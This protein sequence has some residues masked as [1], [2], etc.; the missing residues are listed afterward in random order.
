MI[1]KTI[2]ERLY[3]DALKKQQ[4]IK[5]GFQGGIISLVIV[6]AINYLNQEPQLQALIYTSIGGAVVSLVSFYWHVS[7]ACQVNRLQLLRNLLTKEASAIQVLQAMSQQHFE[8]AFLLQSAQTHQGLDIDI[9]IGGV[10]TAMIDEK[11][12]KIINKKIKKHDPRDQPQQHRDGDQEKRRQ[13]LDRYQAKFAQRS[14]TEE[15]SA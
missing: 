7:R 3:Q 2:V 6:T 11:L 12:I 9:L 15:G 1:H 4:I 13:F 5:G 10:Y 8:V 14:R